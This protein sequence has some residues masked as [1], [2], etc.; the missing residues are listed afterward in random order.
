[1]RGVCHLRRQVLALI[2]AAAV[3][4]VPLAAADGPS[5]ETDAGR[6]AWFLVGAGLFAAALVTA[7]ILAKLAMPPPRPKPPQPG[8]GG[9]SRGD[10]ENEG[11]TESKQHYGHYRIVSRLGSGGAC[12]TY[13]ATHRT[14]GVPVAIKVP[15]PH[16][17]DDPTY[18]D[19]F[20]RAAEAARDLGHE[21]IAKVLDH[22]QSRGTPYLVVDLVVGHTLRS[23]LASVQILPLPRALELSRQIV[24]ALDHA[25]VRGVVHGNLNPDN[26]MI[27][28]DGRA[29]VTDFG[30]ARFEEAPTLSE[31]SM[32][33][34]TPTYL[35]PE[36]MRG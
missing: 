16:C 31:L 27:L 18:R 4:V 28:H 11:H 13:S 10:R 36:A 12:T 9:S 15:H 32:F 7:G 5:D 24:S 17:L 19:R 35:A 34:T 8:A 3:A 21:H 26:V 22:G 30:V 1:V 25:H 20:T 14:D 33:L 6:G 23:H 29:V 2:W